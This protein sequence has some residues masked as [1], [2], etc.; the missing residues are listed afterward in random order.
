MGRMYSLSFTNIDVAAQ[1]DLFQIE[2]IT[3]T[4]VLH[5]VNLS[6]NSDVADAQAENISIVIKRVTDTVVDTTAEVKLEQESRVAHAFLAVNTLTQLTTGQEVLHS[7]AWNIA[8]PFIYLPTPELRP[9]INAN[10][11]LVVNLND[12]PADT[13]TMSGTLNFEEIG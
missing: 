13:I 11:A 10:D 1:Q 6:Q 4:S 9:T 2:A 5:S 12:T 7:E 8:L 3:V